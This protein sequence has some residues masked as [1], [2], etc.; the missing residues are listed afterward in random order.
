MLKLLKGHK[1]IV[2]FIKRGDKV[3]Y[4]KS[5]LKKLGILLLILILE[6]MNLPFIS[7]KTEAFELNRNP[8]IAYSDSIALKVAISAQDL[9][10]ILKDQLAQRE[11]SF[12]IRY[13]SDTTNLK[14][15]IES[16]IEE[17]L[18]SDDY[19][20]SCLKS[21]QCSYKGYENDVTINFDFS[22]YTTK[23]QEDYV[24]SQVTVILKDIITVSMNDDQKEKVIHDYIVT[25]VAYD[26]TLSKFSAYEALKNGKTVCSGYAQLAYKMLNES[27]IETKIISGK[28]NGD[29]HA[30]NL[31]KLQDTWYHLDCTWDD[32][33]PDVVGRVLYN[34]YNLSDEKI[35]KDHSFVKSDYPA[36][37][38]IYT[39]MASIF[40]E[41]EFVQFTKSDN[42]TEVTSTK[43][44]NINFNSGIDGLNL[45]DK[46]FI[47]KKGT[48]IKF[49]IIL[50]VSQD[51][52]T[53]KVLHSIPFELGGNYTLYI[54]KDIKGMYGD[55]N[56]TTSVKMGFT[57]LN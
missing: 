23:L 5:V 25:H 21:Y 57:I 40:D 50:Q 1:I 54:S 45:K 51:K 28:G 15:I 16:S 29:N 52:K 34:Y 20:R 46:I 47:F 53:V 17:I 6:T 38:K 18:K 26:T 43:E 19:L 8:V 3:K 2:Y 24:N 35:S 49:P 27:G 9:S 36:A 30:W 48:N 33:L 42:T 11:T 44:W 14:T 7:V 4:H 13:K 41:S 22:F 12:N 55:I 39:Y 37:T 31:V 32:P 10:S 56:T